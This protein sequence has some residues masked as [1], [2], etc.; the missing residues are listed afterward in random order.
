MAVAASP[1]DSAAAVCTAVS[2]R[3][4]HIPGRASSR[5]YYSQLR[6][7]SPGLFLCGR[8]S[9][10]LRQRCSRTGGA[11]A[12]GDVKRS[13]P[14]WGLLLQRWNGLG[15]SGG[16]RGGGRVEPLLEYT[17][18]ALYCLAHPVPW[19]TFPPRLFAD[20]HAWIPQR[21]CLPCRS[22]N[23]TGLWGHQWLADGDKAVASPPPPPSPFAAQ[24]CLWPS[25]L[26]FELETFPG[27]RPS[28]RRWHERR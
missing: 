1:V 12:R 13:Q 26:S 22:P 24:L 20:P 19:T 21:F 16:T 10:R 6:P 14:L 4:L 8:R 15:G 7:A 28:P 25:L 5:R 2:Q 9:P 3:G 18:A 17:R 11:A 27:R 23:H